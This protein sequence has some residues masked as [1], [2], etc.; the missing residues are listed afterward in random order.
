MHI[1]SIFIALSVT[2]VYCANALPFSWKLKEGPKKLPHHKWTSEQNLVSNQV[3]Q[4]Q[5]QISN[6]D[7]KLQQVPIHREVR[8]F[9]LPAYSA[10]E[11]TAP[12]IQFGGQPPF[13]V[14]SHYVTSRPP[15]F[16]MAYR[17]PRGVQTSKQTTKSL[18]S[19]S[20]SNLLSAHKSTKGWTSV[21]TEIPQYYPSAPR[22]TPT[23]AEVSPVSVPLPGWS[24]KHSLPEQST[25]MSPPSTTTPAITTSFP[26]PAQALSTPVNHSELI[27]LHASDKSPST[28]F[29]EELEPPSS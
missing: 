1:S 14:V 5:Y 22:P 13:S 12:R 21:V 26:R 15:Y 23:P 11:M 24:L 8:S 28:Y 27:D 25:Q 9:G 4:P 29:V 2:L 3:Q 20:N 10:D 19:Y 6:G 17:P 18:T 16:P 7:T